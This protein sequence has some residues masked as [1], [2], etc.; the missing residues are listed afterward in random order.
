[1]DTVFIFCYVLFCVICFSVY[2]FENWFKGSDTT[3]IGISAM[4]IASIVPILNAVILFSTIVE[5][6]V[7]LE[8]AE[9]D[10]KARKFI[11]LKGR[12]K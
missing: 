11:V 2:V 12:N 7:I 10:N 6:A 3:I 4:A 5:I 8:T 1:M 9:L